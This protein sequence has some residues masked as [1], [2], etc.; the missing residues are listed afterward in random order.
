MI[1]VVSTEITSAFSVSLVSNEDQLLKLVLA[2]LSLDGLVSIY[3]SCM[4]RST[5]KTLVA[6][7]DFV[8]VEVRN[9]IWSVGMVS[10][11]F[12]GVVSGTVDI[13]AG[14]ASDDLCCGDGWYSNPMLIIPT[15]LTAILKD[16]TAK[17]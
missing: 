7:S 12:I 17:S 16:G 5:G 10:A 13:L 6:A 15:F 9:F 1:T 14:T 2:E 8:G 11:H 4:L 3:A